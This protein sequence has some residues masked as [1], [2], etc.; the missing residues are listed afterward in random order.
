MVF[1]LILGALASVGAAIG[2][3][4]AT[5]GTS[6]AAFATSIAPTLGTVLGTLKTYAEPLAKF[7]NTF[8]VLLD[9]LK[10]G[11]SIEAMGDRALQAAAQGLKIEQ[12][13]DAKAYTQAL[14][15]L[16]L[17]PEL[18]A[19]HSPALK[20]VAGLG[21][22]TV[23]LED[24]FSAQRGSL[25]AIWLLPLVNASYFTPERMQGLLTAG[26]LGQDV[27][28]Y[29]DRRLADGPAYSFE[30]ALAINP[31]GQAMNDT[32]QA[33]LYAALDDASSEWAKIKQQLN[34]EQGN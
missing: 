32:D 12:F 31:S 21:L 25:N 28:G 3:A 10:P 7:A 24:K 17:D 6:V 9:V 18:S 13:E 5:V 23:G 8:L 19:S 26:R 29:L 11:E 4:V 15:E 1:P 22:A 33:K 16:K 2:S 34:D 14:R 27:L 30:K 20:L